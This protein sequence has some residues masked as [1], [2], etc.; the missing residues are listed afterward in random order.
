MAEMIIIHWND[1]AMYG[2]ESQHKDDV[3]EYGTLEVISCGV[4]VNET[5]KFYTI[6]MDWN[7]E[8]DNYRGVNVIPKTCITKIRKYKITG[9]RI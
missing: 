5:D 7:T 9:K 2:N 4:L 1:A 8:Y 6:A 3:L